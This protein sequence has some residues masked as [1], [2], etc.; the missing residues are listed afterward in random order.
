MNVIPGAE[1]RGPFTETLPRLY[2]DTASAF[3]DPVL[4]LLGSVANF[5]NVVLGTD[6]PYPHDDISIGGVN[7]L[8]E[9]AE[10]DDDS[11][12]NVLGASALRLL[13][14][15]GA[16]RRDGR[17]RARSR[18]AVHGPG[19]DHSDQAMPGHQIVRHARR[20]AATT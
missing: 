11:R 17:A 15:F 7:H 5:D 12:R 19:V 8:R 2:W 18:R 4:H 14:C 3:N 1:E 20:S 16:S 10:L 6:Y 9:S 13:P